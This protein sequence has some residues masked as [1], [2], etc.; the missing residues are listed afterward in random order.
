MDYFAGEVN[1]NLHSQLLGQGW[2]KR[3][4]EVGRRRNEDEEWFIWYF[5]EC[6]NCT[7][8]DDKR[9]GPFTCYL[10]VGQSSDIAIHKNNGRK[11]RF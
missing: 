6:G 9:E 11:M 5:C 7:Q 3:R 2:G 8:V 4:S 10:S 1:S